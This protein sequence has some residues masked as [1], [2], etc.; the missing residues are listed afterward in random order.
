MAQC[1][2][3]GKELAGTV[4]P[5]IWDDIDERF[6]TQC[7]GKFDRIKAEIYTTGVYDRSGFLRKYESFLRSNGFTDSG[8]GCIADHYTAQITKG[9]SDP[10]TDDEA[11]QKTSAVTAETKK[12]EIYTIEPGSSSAGSP[13]ASFCKALGVLTWIGGLILIVKAAQAGGLSAC[14]APL[15]GYGI[16]GGLMFCVAELLQ[17][18][19]RIADSLQGMK[20]LET[21]EKDKNVD[22]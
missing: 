7:K 22:E 12:D 14:I 2:N 21:K 4:P 20:V 9:Q 6:C 19:K 18:I 1:M 8:V 11:G 10:G 17:N 16:A 3:C 5:Q 15:I 13:A